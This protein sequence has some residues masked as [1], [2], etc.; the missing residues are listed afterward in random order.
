MG[1]ARSE[2]VLRRVVWSGK[3]LPLP[4]GV[5][6]WCTDIGKKDGSVCPVVFISRNEYA[7]RGQAS[8]DLAYREGDGL[9]SVGVEG[10]V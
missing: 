8:C 7:E 9:P 6:D 2:Y 3:Q 4:G 10:S 5:V 1:T